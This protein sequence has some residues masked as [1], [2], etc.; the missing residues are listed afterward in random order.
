LEGKKLRLAKL[1]DDQSNKIC[2]VPMD[3]GTTLGPVPGIQNSVATIRKIVR[4][5]ADALILHKGLLRKVADDPELAKARYLLHLS[6][7]TQLSRDHHYKVLTTSVEEA[8]RLGADGVSI[9][10]N[11]G[12]EHDPEM[13]TDLG[14][15][16]KICHEWGMPLLAMMY[17]QKEQKAVAQFAHAARLAEE[18]GA[19]MVKVDYPGSA[20]G[21]ETILNGVCIPVVIAGGAKMERSEE[22]FRLVD[23]AIKAGAS[24]VAIGR[25]IF[26]HQNPELIT[27]LLSSMIHDELK[28]Q[29]CLAQLEKFTYNAAASR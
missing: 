5:G 18:L 2:I 12:T 27:K 8:I 10:V 23:H 7:S 1:F 16:S 15:I 6:V 17:V 20:E 19:D 25:N 29:E 21:L 14:V 11:L 26:Q 28:L 22:L 3:H 9:H 24:G 4:G 13:I